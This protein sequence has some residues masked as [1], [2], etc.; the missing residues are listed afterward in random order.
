LALQQA[1]HKEAAMKVTLLKTALGALMLALLG[2]TALLPAPASAGERQATLGDGG[3][4]TLE[5]VRRRVYVVPDYGYDP[6]YYA[7]DYY[8]AP[9]VPYVPPVAYAAPPAYDYVPPV[10]YDDAPA[11]VAVVGP[12][13][14]VVV[15]Y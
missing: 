1:N 14:G 13:G 15:G 6:D 2:G 11:G 8:A 7:P 5:Q 12:R 4:G 3:Q 9:V 10:D